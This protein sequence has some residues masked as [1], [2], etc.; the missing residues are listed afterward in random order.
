M[1]PA[2]PRWWAWGWKGVSH[3]PTTQGE[4]MLIEFLGQESAQGTVGKNDIKTMP[5]FL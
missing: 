2:A 5:H 3:I 4:D 1:N